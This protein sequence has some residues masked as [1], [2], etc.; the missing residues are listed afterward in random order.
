VLVFRYLAKEVLTTLLALTIILMFILVS[1]QLVGYLNRAANGRIPGLLVLQLMSLEMPNLLSLLLPMGFYISIILSFG[2][3]Y[4]ENEM[5]VLHAC[6][7]SSRRLLAYTLILSSVVAT[8]VAG[9]VLMNPGIAEKRARLLQTSGLKAFIQM[10]SPQ[11][12]H[13][14]PKHQVLYIDEIN[15]QHTQAQGL[16]VAQLNNDTNH[17][18]RWQVIAAKHLKVEQDE[19]VMSQGRIYRM[20]PGVLN[21][22]FGTFEHAKLRL[23]EPT[24]NQENDLRTVSLQT[25]WQHREDNLAMNAE[26]QW[27]ASIVLMAI[28]LSFVAVPLSR[29]NPR[30]GKFAKIL[31]AILIFLVYTNTLFVWRERIVWNGWSSHGSMM[32]VHVF[33][34]ALGLLLAYRQKRQLA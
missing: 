16:F 14:L 32:M 6:G 3:L 18:W 2:R 31:P 13:V 22:Q 7:L 19:L 12:F 4:S 30:S 20:S 33:V 8:I 15:R 23:P 28:T 17:Q 9:M 5:M 11:H 1:N 26:L 24:F 27:R 29:V 21:A 10:I 34:V 25:L